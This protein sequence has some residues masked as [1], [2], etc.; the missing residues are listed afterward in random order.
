MTN[1]QHRSWEVWQGGQF[2]GILLLTRIT[3]KCDALLHFTFFDR[4]LVGKRRLILNFLH[5]C[6]SELGL[7]RISMEIPEFV[8]T[9]VSFCRRKLGF[10][11]EGE[12]RAEAHPAVSALGRGVTGQMQKPHLWVAQQGSR[13]ERAHWHEGTWH[14]VICLRQTKDEYDA[15]V[16]R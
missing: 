6:F 7:H 1:P 11:Y 9:L 15:F 14:D 12:S 10:H 8:G 5:Y 16:R 13:R 3:P 2:V 4:N